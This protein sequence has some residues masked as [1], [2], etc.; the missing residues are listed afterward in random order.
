[1]VSPFGD[2]ER[3][4]RTGDP[5]RYRADGVIEYL[6]R[7]DH[8]VKIRGQ[9]IELGE[10]DARL[11]EQALV[12]DAAVVVQSNDQGQQLVAYLVLEAGESDIAL[13]KDQLKQALP[14]YMVPN[15]FVLLDHMP[16]SPNGKLDRK[17]L[18]APA[19][20]IEQD[21]QAPQTGLQRQVADIWSEVL[22]DQ[23]GL[24]DHFSNWAA[25]LCWRPRWLPARPKLW[26][27]KSRWTFS[28]STA[29]WAASLRH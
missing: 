9:R 21:W 8:Q 25:T 15:Q 5:A 6:G 16:L 13:I 26:A 1:M 19:V 24:N 2:G 20:S 17:A 4:Y 12:R 3:V 11:L 27:L 14:G 29:R 23:V 22:L 28:S 7:L 18:P 10:I